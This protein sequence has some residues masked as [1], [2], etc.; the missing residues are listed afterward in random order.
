MEIVKED[1][2]SDA[3]AKDLIEK[4]KKIGEL[5]YEQKNSLEILKKFT[6]A[7]DKKIKELIE[8]LK[9][10]NLR[11]KQAVQIANFLPQDNEDLRAILHKEYSSFKEDEISKILE[12]VKKI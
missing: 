2:I 6:K 4:R 9:K 12:I 10:L 1:V 5:K 11:D 3:E 7:D 8:E